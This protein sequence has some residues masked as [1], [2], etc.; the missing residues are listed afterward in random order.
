MMTLIDYVVPILIVVFGAVMSYKAILDFMGK[1][2]SEQVEK[3][4]EWLLWAVSE[5]EREY[6]GGTGQL[7][8]RFVYNIA[9]VRFPWV[10]KFVSFEAFSKFVDE[11]LEAMRH[12]IAV[13]TK[14]DAYITGGA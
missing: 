11:A 2:T 5:A 3:F 9:I 1:P 7:K 13:N 8:L 10:E 12:Q 14:F 6:G 4:K